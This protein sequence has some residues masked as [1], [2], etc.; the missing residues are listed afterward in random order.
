MS[1][2]NNT[3]TNSSGFASKY[4]K[5]AQGLSTAANVTGTKVI[6]GKPMTLN[7]AI[8]Y[9]NQVRISDY[10]GKY[11]TLKQM[12]GYT[13][14]SDQTALGYWN[15]FVRDLFAS[16]T[17]DLNTYAAERVG[18]GGG[19]STAAYPSITSKETADFNID[20]IFTWIWIHIDAI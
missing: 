12:A 1:E 11:Q 5:D 10:S 3:T 2:N 6:D 9:F 14:K 18:T 13:G 19:T 7:Q 17:P 16:S 20:K 15:S 4:L 8:N